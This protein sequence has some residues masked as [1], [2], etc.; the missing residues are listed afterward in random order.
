VA[1]LLPDRRLGDEVDV[2]IRI[3]LPALALENAAG[4]TAAGIV[5][6]ARR[7][8]SERH[9]FA[10]LTVFLERTMGEALLVAQLD[11]AQVEH[12]VLHRGGDALALA[13]MGALV[14][15]GDDAEGKMQTCAAVADLRARHERH[16]VAEAGGGGGAAGALRDVLI[17]LAV[18][19]L[20]GT[21]ALDR[22]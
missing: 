19:V 12:A 17:D 14:E 7:R 18:L 20:S 13:A 3:G 11:A 1:D 6:G 2:S 15:R 10:E 22:S 8:V 4:L 5:A 21:K 9:A 16:V